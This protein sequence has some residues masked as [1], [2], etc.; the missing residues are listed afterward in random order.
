MCVCVCEHACVRVC[1]SMCV[2]MCM[3]V[4]NSALSEKCRVGREHVMAH[5]RFDLRQK[6][7]ECIMS[8]I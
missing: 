1:A 7:H 2:C 4:C 8:H 5:L 6:R 3:C